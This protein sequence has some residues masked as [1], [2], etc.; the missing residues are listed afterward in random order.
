MSYIS[1]TRIANELRLLQDPDNMSMFDVIT[2]DDMRNFRVILN[3]PPDSVYEGYRFEL[4][5]CIPSEYPH[6]PPKVKFI[7]PIKHLNINDN[8]DICLDIIKSKNWTGYQNIRSVIISII[9]LL[10][11]PNPNDPLD[12]DL[13]QM[14]RES[15][16]N[17]YDY[18]RGC[19]SKFSV[20][21]T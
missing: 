4:S 2:Q 8:G 9:S 10:S 14:Y 16:S 5:V 18:V 21:H 1:V 17:Y 7:T 11:D 12:F 20:K 3:G 6:C 15:P 19:C 13:G